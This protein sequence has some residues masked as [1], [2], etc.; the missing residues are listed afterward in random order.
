MQQVVREVLPFAIA[1]YLFDALTWVGARQVVFV[2]IF[3]KNFRIRR[4]G[5]NLLGLLPTGI[6][7]K[8]S[9]D[10]PI[11]T[12]HGVWLPPPDPV[13]VGALTDPDCYRAVGLETAA[14][15]VL[16]HA[17]VDFGGGLKWKASGVPAA[18]HFF[19]E[20]SEVVQLPVGNREACIRKHQ[21]AAFDH[22]AAGRRVDAFLAA[23]DPLLPFGDALF[24]LMFLVLPVLALVAPSGPTQLG[25]V[26]ML[27]AAVWLALAVMTFRLS[28]RLAAEGTLQP[29]VT[30]LVTV[31]LPPPLASRGVQVLAADLL[32]DF[33]P[34]AA[35]AYLLSADRLAPL[36]RAEIAAVDR[37]LAAD[38]PDDWRHAWS[39][40]REAVNHLLDRLG[41]SRAELVPAASRDVGGIC[42]E[43]SATYRP[44][45][46][47]CSDCDVLLVAVSTS[48]P[49]ITGI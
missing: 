26:S 5:L 13:A 45:F 9:H 2:S 40:R 16:E 8:T 43:C 15:A 21:Q 34:A 36:L 44:G 37:A 17:T 28:R 27:T 42:P 4:H 41:I 3:G 18:R 24:F 6:D 38:G 14:E 7:F 49:P 19:S 22:L 20:L 35:A 10:R 39:R 12:P 1:L 48:S 11:L 29:D 33:E 31:L 46:D 23:V 47:R 30:R 25:A 32:H